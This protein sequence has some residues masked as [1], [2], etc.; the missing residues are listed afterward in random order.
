MNSNLHPGFPGNAYKPAS[1][2]LGW[3]RARFGDVMTVANVLH[4]FHWA[5]P[6]DRSPSSRTEKPVRKIVSWE[7]D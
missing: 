6:W 3:T 7:D 4:D 2:L 5:A 1:Y